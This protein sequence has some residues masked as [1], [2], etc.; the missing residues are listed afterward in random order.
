M[1]PVNAK[2]SDYQHAWASWTDPC[3]CGCRVVQVDLDSLAAGPQALLVPQAD[4]KGGLLYRHVAP[5]ELALLKGILPRQGFGEN[6]RL[7][8]CLLASSTSP[9]QSAWI[10]GAIRRKLC[11]MGIFSQ[12]GPSQ[13]QVLHRQR[14]A[15]LQAARELGLH[16]ES[17]EFDPQLQKGK[18][19]IC[20]PVPTTATSLCDHTQSS[21]P[22]GLLVW[23]PC[24]T[25]A[26]EGEESCLM[27]EGCN[28]LAQGPSDRAVVPSPEG[29]SA[30][31]TAFRDPGLWTLAFRA[32][33]TGNLYEVAR[34]LPLPWH[35]VGETCTSDR[36]LLLY[37]VDCHAECVQVGDLVVQGSELL[38]ALAGPRPANA[39]PGLPA[40]SLP[41]GCASQDAFVSAADRCEVLAWHAHW[42]ADDQLHA[43]LTQL[44]DLTERPLAVIDPLQLTAILQHG[45]Y[46]LL[47]SAFRQESSEAEVISCLWTAG[48]WIAVHW[49][50]SLGQVFAWSSV[51]AQVHV[52][53]LADAVAEAN[54]LVAKALGRTVRSFLFSSGPLRPPVLGLCGHFAFADLVAH[55]LGNEVP[56]DDDALALAA[57]FVAH[58]EVGLHTA[59]GVRLPVLVGGGLPP[60]IEAGLSATLRQKGVPTEVADARAKEAI[61][62][63]GIAKIQEAMQSTNP[64]RQ[65]KAVCSNS[66][67]P[68]QLVLPSELSGMVAAKVAAGEPLGPK[69]K[70]KLSKARLL[71][72]CRPKSWHQPQIVF[73]SR[74][75]S[76][77]AR[78]GPWPNLIAWGLLGRRQLVWLLFRPKMRSPICISPGLSRAKP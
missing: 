63:V 70:H 42:L 49:R 39:S 5:P 38:L 73:A 32:P 60:F 78:T 17:T 18:E 74:R 33:C 35:Q 4:E 10:F 13:V 75:G 55:V 54:F 67:P 53:P 59:H 19:V 12:D 11:V 15:L 14:R 50:F 2:A 41:K 57:T 1:G 76:L 27:V 44:A 8:L 72:L 69:R 26:M 7:A 31:V 47:Q 68:F 16:Q 30:D 6:P 9:L 66:S 51:A 20:S 56:S 37:A 64:W 40:L 28:S 24:C 71:Q 3:P 43:M 29:K 21:H 22:G 77:S 23:P 34:L 61:Q 62:R 36:L 58:F 52:G 46:G 48:H 65:L 45:D 25:A